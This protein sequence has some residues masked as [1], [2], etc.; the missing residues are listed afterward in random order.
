[1]ITFKRFK[2]LNKGGYIKRAVGDVPRCGENGEFIWPRD[3][4][5]NC[6]DMVVVDFLYQPL[7][8][9]YTVYLSDSK[10]L[11]AP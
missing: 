2:E 7:N 11:S 10:G 1:M 5:G 9:I 6:D 4:Y 8:G 3:L